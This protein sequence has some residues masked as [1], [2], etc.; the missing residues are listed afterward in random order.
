MNAIL[1]QIAALRAGRPVT[2]DYKNTNRYRIVARENDGTKT[3][4]YFSA[5]IYQKNTRK[6]I[7]PGFYPHMHGV[8]ACGSNASITIC[9]LVDMENEQGRCQLDLSSTFVPVSDRELACGAGRLY[10]TTNGVA[11]LANVKQGP[12][13]LTVQVSSPFWTVRAND[14]CFALMQEDFRPFVS[15]SAIGT[16]ATGREII[17]PARIDYQKWTDQTYELT[18]TPWSPMGSYVLL[19]ANLYEPK[20]FQDTTVE[21][22]HPETNNA[23]GTVAFVGDTAAYGEQWLYSRPDNTRMAELAGRRIE[24]AVLHLPRYGRSHAPIKAFRTQ[25]RFCSFGSN[26][27]NKVGAAAPLS[28]S[29]HTQGYQ[30][31]DITALI[32]HPTTGFYLQ[33]DGLILRSRAKGS[34][35][36]AVATGD[37]CFAPQILEVNFP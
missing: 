1:S 27:E 34:G 15:I 22:R 9:D 24:K 8:T 4:Y 35:F 11:Y 30:S 23:F 7:D 16:A 17:A 2:I 19:E 33:S 36:S 10:P 32:T 13:R 37:S 14:R 29:I 20:L 31:L 12:A 21:S 3:A 26:W 5:P 28:D 18:L 25:R 6:L